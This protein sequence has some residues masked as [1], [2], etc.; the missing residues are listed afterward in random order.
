[1]VEVGGAGDWAAPDR[2]VERM[3]T[4]LIETKNR[5]AEE[6]SLRSGRIFKTLTV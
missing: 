3:K 2:F 4:A 1:M 6:Y 5:L